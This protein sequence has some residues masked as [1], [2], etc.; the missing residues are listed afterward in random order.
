MNRLDKPHKERIFYD[1]AYLYLILPALVTV[2]G[3]FPSYFKRLAVTDGAHHLH[4]IAATLW[5]LLL[6]IQ[7]FLYRE[8]KIKWH[9][10]LGKVS[11]ILVPLII[12]SGLNMVHIMLV[13]KA[14]YVG[15]G[16]IY[17]PTP[18]DELC[19]PV[20]MVALLDG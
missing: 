2:V 9:R 8:G 20:G 19:R 6:I 14:L 11:F 4:G 18:I 16:I 1:R 15:F 10:K 5:I 17:S 3:F 7:P 13:N 12:V